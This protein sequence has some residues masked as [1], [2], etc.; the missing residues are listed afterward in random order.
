MARFAMTIA[1]LGTALFASAFAAKAGGIAVAPVAQ[2]PALGRSLGT[3]GQNLGS[4]AGIGMVPSAGMNVSTANGLTVQTSIDNSR[5]IQASSSVTINETV[6]GVPVGG[7]DGGA[8]IEA[9]QSQAAADAQQ[10]FA[11]RQ[12][13][14]QQIEN[15]VQLVVQVWQAQQGQSQEYQGQ[16]YWGPSY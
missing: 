8:G 6:N 12:A 9:V 1:L 16:G 2:V 14:N 5:N 10:V 13:A 11:Q 3:V 4:S 7:F 15:E